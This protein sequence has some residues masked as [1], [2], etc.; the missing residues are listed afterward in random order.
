MYSKPNLE[1]VSDSRLKH[2]FTKVDG[3]YRIAK[4]I[5][6]MCI[7]APHNIFKD[8]PFSRIDLISC[9]N[10]MIYIDN[11]L[12]KKILSTFHYSLNPGG[13]LVLGKS[14]SIIN[15]NNNL[16][17]Q[18]DR[19]FKIYNVKK[20]SRAKPF[21]VPSPKVIN[22]NFRE[23]VAPLKVEKKQTR[24]ADLE[25]AVDAMMLTRYIPASVVINTDLDIVQFRGSTGVFLEPAPG[26]ASLNLLKMAR[27]GLGFELR[28]AIHKVIKSGQPTRKK[29]IEIKYK[30]Q[31]NFI[32]IEVIPLKGND[33][34]ALPGGFRRS[35]SDQDGRF[36]AGQFQKCSGQTHCPA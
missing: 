20:E 19:K 26:K 1:N 12:Q 6:D 3:G 23:A 18:V 34:K 25:K 9:C 5:R 35:N 8:P 15:A 10:L 13:F 33:E 2:F 28:N 7:F 16:F 36:P 21:Y 32:N 4:P 29:S 17:S 22:K 31:V 27:E 11:V 24:A 14:E 30:N